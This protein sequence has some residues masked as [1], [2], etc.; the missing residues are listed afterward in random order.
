MKIIF[1]EDFHQV[2]T[3]DPAAEEGRLEYAEKILREKYEFIT[4]SPCTEKEILLV[5]SQS[6]HESVKW[7]KNIYKI[8]L[9]AAGASILAAD[10]A[11]KGEFAFA[12][13]RPPG[14]HASPNNAW[15]F[16]YFNN[17]AIAIEKLF[18]DKSI[19]NAIIIDIDQ[20]Y[21]DGTAE[22]FAKNPKLIYFHPRAITPKLFIKNIEDFLSNKQTDLI[23]ISAGFDRHREDWGI[24]LATEDYR[25]IG[26]VLGNFAREKCLG[27]LFLVLEGGYNFTTLGDSAL[28]LIE[29]LS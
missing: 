17:V 21:G 16:C 14:H 23:A 29:G 26:K 2:Y 28:A 13:C 20:H 3:Y 12:L 1:H 24:L 4:P 19:D 25:K 22:H 9:L 11:V 7:E 27:K 18:K 10:Y 8:A 5:H 15:G 6:H